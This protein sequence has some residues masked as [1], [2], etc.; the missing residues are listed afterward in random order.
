MIKRP[1][2]FAALAL[3]LAA[4]AYAAAAPNEEPI[5]FEPRSGE[6]VEAFSG[7]LTVPM[8]RSDPSSGTTELAYVRFPATTDTPGNPIVYLSG[9]PGGSGIGTAKGPRFP[10]FMAMRQH[11][12]V[13]AFDQRGTGASEQPGRC[14]SSVQVGE[15]EILSDEQYA[16][17]YRQATRECAAFW[18][19]EGVDLRGF[20]T[21]E[22]A[23]DISDLRKHL[24]AE[25]VS[26]WSI[27]YGSHLAM[28]SIAAIPDDLDRVI[29]ASAEGLDQTVKLP[30]RTLAYFGRLQA[31]VDA[32]PEAKKLYPD[33]LGLITRVQAKLEAEPMK[34]TVPKRDGGSYDFLMQKRNLQE[35]SS[36]MIADPQIAALMLMMYRQLDE[37][38][39]T[40]ASFVLQRFWSPGEPI[41]MS[42]MTT[43]MDRASGITPDR[44]K[45]FEEQVPRSPVGGYL[46]FPMPQILGEL[47][48]IDLGPSFRDGPF[49]DTPVLL[50]TGTLDGRTYP[51]GQSEAV[52]G[53]NDVTQIIVENAGHNL[54]MTSPDVG[55]AMHKFMRGEDVGTDRII[56]ETPDL[57]KMPN[58]G[59]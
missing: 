27:S 24:G 10:L 22:S 56:V 54:F 20:T 18:K 59:G 4:P 57:S 1:A 55:T 37:G 35:F 31:A 52:A 23:Q 39:T 9:G 50:L 41:V 38:D 48:D 16:D 7:T 26:L 29:M 5:T 30:A 49:G 33:V 51:E 53:L 2:L 45:A 25:K 6:K 40:L 17:R 44:L 8:N 34:V 12:D 15:M 13:I 11:G 36:G 58:L 21:A 14:T 3:A 42:A 46:N 43:A 28:A 32:Q 19:A 47:E